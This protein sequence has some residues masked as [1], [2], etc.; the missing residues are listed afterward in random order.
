MKTTKIMLS[1][2]LQLDKQT[3]E[4][5]NMIPV[6]GRKYKEHTIKD[7]IDQHTFKPKITNKYDKAIELR[8]ARIQE[9][10]QDDFRS[11]DK[12]R[13][14][15][16]GPESNRVRKAFNL[17][18]EDDDNYANGA[19]DGQVNLAIDARQRNKSNPNFEGSEN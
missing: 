14:F 15:E 19:N 10:M 11:V 13:I 2:R 16:Q 12:V 18:Y 3:H 8:Y 6:D 7:V 4:T 9:Q 5:L 17:E 1:P